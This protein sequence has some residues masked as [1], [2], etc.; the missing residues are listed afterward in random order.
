MDCAGLLP[1]IIDRLL[2]RHPRL[3]FSSIKQLPLCRN[4]ANCAT[5][6]STWC[7]VG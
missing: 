5:E 2:Q 7:S 1:V 3:E 4:S 6:V